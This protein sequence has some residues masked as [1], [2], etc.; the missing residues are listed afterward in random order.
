MGNLVLNGSTSGGITISPPAVAGSNTISLP[1][2]TGTVALTANPTFTGVTT[3][4]TITSPAATNLTLQ[5]AGTTA[6]TIDTSQRVGIGTTSPGQKLSVASSSNIAYF[7]SSTSDGYIRVDE[8]GGTNN[9]F[10]GLNGVGF[11]GTSSNYPFTIRTNNVEQM[12]IG[13]N[14]EVMINTTNTYGRLFVSQ[15]VNNTCAFFSLE[16]TTSAANVVIRSSTFYTTQYNM[17]VEYQGVQKGS[18]TTNGSNAAFNT[19]SDYRLKENV[20]PLAN[21]LTNIAK[22]RPVSYGWIGTANTG[23]GFLAH[24]L[25][26]VIPNAVHGEKDAINDDGSIKPQ[27]VDYSK[28]VVHLVAAIQELS[29][30]NDALTARIA[31]LEAK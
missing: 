25:A 11:V 26:E 22:L 24:E 2:N 12:R 6:I 10:G 14:G 27:Q 30:K 15:T 7:N 5:S 16:S 21:A 8:T 1:A 13:P 28:I 9:I 3:E 20:Q 4:S 31:A 19:S 23:E 17:S 18:I 29:A